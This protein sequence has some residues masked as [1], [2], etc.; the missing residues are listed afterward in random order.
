LLTAPGCWQQRLAQ[1]R[2]AVAFA[3]AERDAM[4]ED[5]AVRD[6]ARAQGAANATRDIGNDILKWKEY[7]PAPSPPWQAKYVTLLK[8]RCNVEWEVVQGPAV[9][10]DKLREEVAAYNEVMRVEIERRFGADILQKLR[11][12]AEGR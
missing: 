3:R 7:P 11:D 9:V 6:A 1:Q 10:S 2:A 4:Q 5:Q 12:E 8:E